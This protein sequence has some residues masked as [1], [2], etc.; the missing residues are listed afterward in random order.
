MWGVISD[1]PAGMPHQ[2]PSIE[3]SGRVHAAFDRGL[4]PAS[5]FARRLRM[6]QRLGRSGPRHHVCE[7]QLARV[8]TRLIP[9]LKYRGHPTSDDVGGYGLGTPYGSTVLAFLSSLGAPCIQPPWGHMTAIDLAAH[10]VLLEASVGLVPGNDGWAGRTW[11]DG[12][13][14]A[15][16]VIFQA[17][18]P[19]VLSGQ[20]MPGTGKVLW[21]DKLPPAT[22]PSCRLS[23]HG[24]TRVC[25]RRCRRP[26]GD[27]STSDTVVA[28][29]LPARSPRTGT[30]P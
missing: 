10:R 12:A 14:T 26:C 17:P 3:L 20:S 30:S 25:R 16:G 5:G 24:W 6:G 29:A 8:L 15:G 11:V 18:R 2:V 4:H 7:H 1:R 21:S 27:G 28:Y 19:T 13:V 9:Q 23:G 22:R